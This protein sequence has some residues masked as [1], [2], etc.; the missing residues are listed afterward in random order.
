MNMQVWQRITGNQRVQP[1][2]LDIGH[3]ALKMVQLAVC[4]D[5]IRVLAARRA[6]LD[7]DGALDAERW[8]QAVIGAVRRL[9]SDN[10]FRGRQVVSALP[11]DTLKITSV[12]LSETETPQA[13][14]FL[15]REAAERF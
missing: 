15:R 4:E 14:K 7:M 3:K 9:L 1:I 12:R 13:E 2:G 5:R 11:I 8:E 6:V 10:Q